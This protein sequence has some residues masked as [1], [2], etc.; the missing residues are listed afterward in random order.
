ML[1]V[2][3]PK[4]MAF[5]NGIKLLDMMPQGYNLEYV[6]TL[7]NT[8]G[9]EGRTIYQFQQIPVDMIYPFLFGMSY[10]LTMGYFLNKLNKLDSIFF[11]LCLLA[12]I[13]GISD[14]IEN[15]GIIA[16]LN[17]FPDITQ[18]LVSTTSTFSLIKSVSTTIYFIALIVILI[19]I[20]INALRT[21]LSEIK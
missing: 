15:I 16:M 7:F 11:Y 1:L 10:C 5:S 19:V 2:T 17:N 20:G 14:Y 13:A 6:K 12:P 9:V 3:I 4:T 21:K 18:T 8:L